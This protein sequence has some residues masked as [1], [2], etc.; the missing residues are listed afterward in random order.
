MHTARAELLV[1]FV[2]MAPL[3][4]FGSPTGSDCALSIFVLWGGKYNQNSL[5]PPPTERYWKGAQRASANST[6]H[7]IGTYEHQ[8]KDSI[9]TSKIKQ[10]VTTSATTT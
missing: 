9:Q 8:K 10:V 4:P 1:L 5:A 3:P 2:Q 6:I 7:A